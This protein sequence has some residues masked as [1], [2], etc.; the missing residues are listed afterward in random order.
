MGEF[1]WTEKYRPEKVADCILPGTIKNSFQS[2][3]LEKNM[4]NLIL[5]GI[6][7]VGK[8]SV[9]IATLI[10]MDVDYI[11]INSALKRGMDTV[12]E[13]MTQFATTLSMQ[14]GRKF[15]VL[16]EADGIL[17]DAQRALNAFIEEYSENCGFI[18]TCNNKKKIIEPI[19]SRCVTIDFVIPPSE[20]S[21]LAKEFYLALRNILITEGVSCPKPVVLGEIIKKYYPDW[22]QILNVVQHYAQKNNKVI[23]TGILSKTDDDKRKELIPY[24]KSKNW[25]SMRNWVG[26]NFLYLGEFGSFASSLFK[27]LQDEVERQSH[28]TLYMTMNEYDFRSTRVT[29]KE[30]NMVAFL[31]E[32]MNEVRFK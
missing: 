3:V 7:G 18:F 26:E 11:K 6:P 9:A 13:E 21:T 19:H 4:P 12:R 17:P 10:E 1:I 30:I 8:T 22:R 27:L 5:A 2:F 20:F 24:L 23:D 31:T 16:D 25:H 28:S 15:I 29:D 14:G 32:V